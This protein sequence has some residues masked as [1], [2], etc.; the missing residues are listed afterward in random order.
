MDKAKIKAAANWMKLELNSA[1]E[2]HHEDVVHRLPDFDAEA[3]AEDM[4]GSMRIHK[5][6]LHE[7]RRITPDAVWVP[8]DQMWRERTRGDGPGRLASD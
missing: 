8:G 4:E 1:G 5:G 7:F 2:L 3:V 6:V